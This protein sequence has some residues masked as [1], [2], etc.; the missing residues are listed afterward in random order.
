MGKYNIFEHRIWHC[1]MD[2]SL[3]K[4]SIIWSYRHR[5]H[6]I[7]LWY[8]SLPSYPSGIIRELAV[9]SHI[10]ARPRPENQTFRHIWLCMVLC[11]VHI[12]TQYRQQTCHILCNTS[13]IHTNEFINNDHIYLYRRYTVY[14]N[15]PISNIC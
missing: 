15:M 7:E 13:M 10:A 6:L 11:L 8:R 9:M 3:L 1:V 4:Y 14:D 12:K 5:P 2:I